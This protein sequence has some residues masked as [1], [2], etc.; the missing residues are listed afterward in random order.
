V[1]LR[2]HDLHRYRRG[3]LGTLHRQRHNRTGR[4]ANLA[5]DRVDLQARGRLTVD[6]DDHVAGTHAGF[7][8]GITVDRVD[9][10]RA[11]LLILH[12]VDA[13]A[14]EIAAVQ[15]FVEPVD[16]LRRQVC[17]VRVAESAEHPRDRD[18]V[19]M[20]RGATVA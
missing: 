17:R 10:D 4:S 18:C 20:S 12:D 3:R 8:G 1:D 15:L 19:K 11:R 7:D 2:A 5:L 9:Q 13:D 14:G 16:L 6:G